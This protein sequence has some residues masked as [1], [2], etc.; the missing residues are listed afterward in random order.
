[1]NNNVIEVNPREFVAWMRN[2]TTHHCARCKEELCTPCNLRPGM[3]EAVCPH[4]LR[5]VLVVV[6]EEQENYLA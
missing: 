4:C 6:V 1:M 3:I 2:A 5:R